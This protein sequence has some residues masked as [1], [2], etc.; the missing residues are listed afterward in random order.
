MMSKIND[1]LQL[2]KLTE[3]ITW[4]ETELKDDPL[5][6]DYRSSLIEMLCIRGELERAD[7]QLNIMVLKHPEYIIGAN[8]LR[9]L[10]RAQQCRIDFENGVS[11]PELFDS[12]TPYSEALIKL[13]IELHNGD[14][15]SISRAVRK[16]EETRE[17][18]SCIVNKKTVKD[19][20]DLD[21]TLGGFIEI[22]GTD[23]KYYLAN[24]SNIE[25]IIFKPI[26]S[27]IERV[28]R[29]VELSIKDGPSGE[30]HVPI[31]YVNSKTDAQKLG[32]ETDWK[33]RS[34]DVAEGLGLKT[35]FADDDLVLFSEI[36]RLEAST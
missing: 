30:A 32:R 29:R 12:V 15:K 27:I 25:Y 14:D 17:T 11:V 20:R 34:E 10:L 28:W 31:V 13:S 36:E 3:A 7:A 5:N 26:T 23:G 8:N 16:F 19:F 6:T 21:D 35:W 24:M 22:F 4:L 1:M 2:G 9:Q 33:M 18:I